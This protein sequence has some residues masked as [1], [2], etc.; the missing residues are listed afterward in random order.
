MI[1]VSPPGKLNHTIA[2]F[3]YPSVST[4]PKENNQLDEL[5][6]GI[7][8]ALAVLIKILLNN[9][10]VAPTEAALAFVTRTES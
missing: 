1:K 10:S 5:L 9:V 2:V 4:I 7:P 8:A 3:S 6:I